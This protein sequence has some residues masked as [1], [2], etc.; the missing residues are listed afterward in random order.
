MNRAPNAVVRPAAAQVAGHRLRNLIV[1]GLRSLGQQSRRGH[2]LTGL[3]ISALRNLLLDPRL[4]QRMQSTSGQALNGGDVFRGG[5][6]DWRG[7]GSHG[8]SIHVDRTCATQTGATAEFC[9]RHFQGIAQNPE[10]R[11]LRRNIH[12]PLAAV[13]VQSD[14]CHVLGV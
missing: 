12:F 11:R 7:T 8:G 10:Q 1:G 13:D 9:A 3:T 2:D 5:L 14:G 4:L 6:R